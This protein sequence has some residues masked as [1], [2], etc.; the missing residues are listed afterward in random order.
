MNTARIS[1]LN[2][3]KST[4]APRTKKRVQ[5]DFESKALERLDKMVD[6]TGA[7]TRAEVIRRALSVFA[8][9]VD[10]AERGANVSIEEPD[11]TRTK[12][13]PMW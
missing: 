12:C 4:N 11:G 2:T 3:E 1:M 6:S 8:T 9:F 13:L 5:F 10:A 7:T